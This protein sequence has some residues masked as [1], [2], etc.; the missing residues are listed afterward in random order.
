MNF[1]KHGFRAGLC[2]LLAAALACLSAGT[3]GPGGKDGAGREAE[4]A[5]AV[6]ERV[7]LEWYVDSSRVAMKKE[8]S[9]YPVLQEISDKTGVEPEI[10]IPVKNKAEKLDLMIASGRFPDLMTLDTDNVYINELIRMK[11]IKPLDELIAQYVPAFEGEI[12]GQLRRDMLY[13]GRMYGLPGSYIPR[14][15]YVEKEG[16]GLS[17]YNVRKDV[18]LEL[19]APP[20]DTPERFTAA[21]R[22]FRQ[23]YPVIGGK[24]SVPFSLFGIGDDQLTMLERSFGIR[25]YYEDGKKLVSKYKDPAYIQ[26]VKFLNGLYEEGLMDSLAFIKKGEQI[27]DDLEQGRIFCIP[28]KYEALRELTRSLPAGQGTEFTAVEPMK[29][30]PGVS[31][32][33]RNR[34]GTTFTMIP[35]ASQKQEEAIRFIRY[36]WGKDANLLMNYGHEGQDYSIGNGKITRSGQ[37]L[38]Q[39]GAD[40]E[41]FEQETGI[42]VFPVLFYPYASNAYTADMQWDDGT[43][44]QMADRYF[45]SGKTYFEGM[46]P[47]YGLPIGRLQ[48]KLEDIIQRDFPMAIMAESED[49]AVATFSSMLLKMEQSGLGKLEQYWTVQY[50]INRARYR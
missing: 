6:R 44:R 41:R 47:D 4:N 46:N 2:I 15:M 8:W 30:V 3:P 14:E 17:T 32:P 40:R 36:L 7:R 34:Y 50:R 13:D 43:G 16:M 20:M 28:A 23:K 35:A 26:L 1:R 37:V 27:R 48:S 29:A 11:K 39:L 24:P 38:R 9:R 33:G 5:A 45:D 18:Y 49:N 31:F 12:D 42:G 19:G 25:E 22:L 21:L 10:V